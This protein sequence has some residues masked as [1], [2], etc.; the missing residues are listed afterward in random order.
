MNPVFERYG[1]HTYVFSAENQILSMDGGAA[2]YAYDGDGKRMKKVTSSETTFTFYGLGGIISEFTTS[3]AIANHIAA[4]SS[5]NCF[6]HTTD[7]LGSAVLVMSATGTVVENSRT[8]PYG[9]TWL[10]SDTGSTSTNDKKFT[11]YL[12]DQESGLDY[13]MNRYF[14]NTTGRFS[15]PDKGSAAL[16]SP[17]SLNRYTF[18]NLDPINNT[19]STGNECGDGQICYA[20]PPP[21]DLALLAF[22]IG[23]LSQRGAGPIAIPPS[24]AQIQSLILTLTAQA[25]KPLCDE[26]VADN[27]YKLNF[28]R[29]YSADAQALSK[30]TGVDADFI[31]AWA[32]MESGWGVGYD[33]N[34]LQAN[35]SGPGV[36][37]AAQSNNNFFGLTTDNWIGSISCGEGARPGF[38]CF[39]LYGNGT[40]GSL[41]LIPSG[42]AALMSGNQRYLNA[43]LQAQKDPGATVASIADAVAAAGFNSEGNYGAKV[44]A[45]ANEI[46]ARKNCP[47]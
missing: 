24:A 38:A 8:L 42:W 11:T 21:A 47:N 26:S 13:A 17:T 35:P 45:D 32:A 23:G 2:T 28:M 30:L 44:A 37:S 5:D 43:A 12:R 10:A 31:L 14:V 9:E 39:G 4:A 15:S 29:T 19:D 20:G 40:G 27:S 7:K 25:L 6:Y 36:I 33:G 18:A 34:K 41:S 3:N 1:L 16:F 46:N 22:L